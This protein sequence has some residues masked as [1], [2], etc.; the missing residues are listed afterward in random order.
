MP[1]SQI[2]T[3]SIATG[4]VSAADLASGAALSNLGS[5]QLDRANMASGSVLQV[6]SA[7][8]NSQVSTTSQS[9]VTTSF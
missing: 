1:I 5:S 2:N 7:S 4:A 8:S 6:V 9:A 3:N